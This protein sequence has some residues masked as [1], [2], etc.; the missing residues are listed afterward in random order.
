MQSWQRPLSDLVK[1]DDSSRDGDDLSGQI[2]SVL[3]G[4]K[5]LGRDSACTRTRNVCMRVGIFTHMAEGHWAG[6]GEGAGF[7]GLPRASEG[8]G[9]GSAGFRLGSGYRGAWGGG[10]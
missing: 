5:A 8:E 1:P 7:R 3:A 9:P 2:V 6:V 10:E 4:A